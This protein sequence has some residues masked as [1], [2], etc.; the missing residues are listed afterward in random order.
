MT[1]RQFILA[2]LLKNIGF[3][4]RQKRLNDAAD[5]LQ[6]LYEAEGILGQSI[7]LNTE[8]LEHYKINYLNIKRKLQQRAEISDKIQEIKDKI[9]SIKQENKPNFEDK[10][11]VGVLS[12]E[13]M[14][15]KQMIIVREL[16]SQQQDIS[17]VAKNIR[18]LYTETIWKLQTL[19]DNDSDPEEILVEEL[20]IQ[21]LKDK[22]GDL[23][24]NKT[25]IAN[26]LSKQQLILKKISSNI[27]SNVTSYKSDVNNVMERAQKA[28]SH[29]RS[30]CGQLDGKIMEHYHEI[31]KN[32]SQD[33]FTDNNCLEAAKERA[34]L[35][36][37]MQAIRQ[38]VK[39]NYELAG[40]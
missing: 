13:D 12:F 5:E 20:N 22:F 36:K 35:I 27:N 17:R 6:L 33:F 28:I 11:S 8:K 9:D 3:L 1:K 7:W 37:L 39:Y 15:Y 2:N 25:S 4:N 21:R 29:Y 14:L 19:I 26:E 32:I 40:R 31:G 34:P 24:E 23:K 38:S 10:L 16:A 18:T 30:Q